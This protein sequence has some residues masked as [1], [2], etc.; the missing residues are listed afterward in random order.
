MSAV[1]DAMIVFYK[2]VLQGS[3]KG[4]LQGSAK[5]VLQGSAKGALQGRFAQRPSVGPSMGPNEV[6]ASTPT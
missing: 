6:N 5:G 4:V 1:V 2:G 3:A